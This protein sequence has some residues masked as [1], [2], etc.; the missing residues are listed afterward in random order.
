MDMSKPKGQIDRRDVK[1]VPGDCTHSQ[2]SNDMQK[3]VL[4]LN[5]IGDMLKVRYALYLNKIALA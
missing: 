2:H 1:M 5:C 3:V 4:T